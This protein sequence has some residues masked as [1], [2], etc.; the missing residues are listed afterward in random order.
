MKTAEG[1]EQ[2]MWV[3]GKWGATMRTK[4]KVNKGSVVT[5]EWA[6]GGT[7]GDEVSGGKR[8]ALR[9]NVRGLAVGSHQGVL[10][11]EKEYDLTYILKLL[12]WL[13]GRINCREW[14]EAETTQEATGI[15]H[16]KMDD[17]LD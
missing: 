14:K 1:R 12:F 2:A 9:A 5:A 10:W 4:S 13:L 7:A 15:I 6:R 3:S 11:S 16:G 17:N 8:G